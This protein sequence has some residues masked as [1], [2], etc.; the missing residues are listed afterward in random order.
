VS[1]VGISS[2][3]SASP[4]SGISGQAT[5]FTANTSGGNGTYS[6]LWSFGD[7]TTSTAV[8][9]T[10]TYTSIGYHT[11][12]LVT[13]DTAGHSAYTSLVVYT[14]TDP[15]PDRD[16][17]YTYTSTYSGSTISDLC[18]YVAGDRA[19]SGCP[20]ISTYTSGATLL[21]ML[22]TRNTCIG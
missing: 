21:D 4:L 10:Y 11:V 2:S 1:G 20:Y 9:P 5:T 12:T 14:G 3:I 15:D 8:S 16:G 18:P 22:S 13:T 19:Y 6:Y 7:G 17:I